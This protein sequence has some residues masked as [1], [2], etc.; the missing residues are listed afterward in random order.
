MGTYFSHTIPAESSHATTAHLDSFKTQED[1]TNYFIKFSDIHPDDY[2]RLALK[3]LKTLKPDQMRDINNVL[4]DNEMTIESKWKK[5]CNIL[6]ISQINY[7][8]W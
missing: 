1:Y 3:K 7:V 5:Y 2:F 8:G 4:D 6:D